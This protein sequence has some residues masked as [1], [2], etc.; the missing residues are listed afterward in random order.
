MQKLTNGTIIDDKYCVLDF[1]GIGGM[2]IVY[3]VE[4]L[5]LKAVR[6]LKMIDTNK[7]S[8]ENWRRFQLEARAASTLEHTNI[9]KV[10]DYGLVNKL[11]P[12]Y[13]ME[14]VDGMTLGERININGPINT[15]QFFSVFIPVAQALAYIHSKGILH[16]D[17]K[18]AN[19]MLKEEING[20]VSQVKVLDFGLVKLFSDA[21]C[22]VLT[23][24]GALTKA[25]EIIGSPTFMSP[26]QTA[27]RKLDQRSDIYS[28]GCAMF[29]ALTGEPP[30]LDYN[31][32]E[33]LIMHQSKPIPRLA[34]KAQEREFDERIELLVRVM[35]AKKPGDRHQ[36]MEEVVQDLI[37]IQSGRKPLFAIEHWQD[38][39]EEENDDIEADDTESDDVGRVTKRTNIGKSLIN[40]TSVITIAI[41]VTAI[42]TLVATSAY[43]WQIHDSGKTPNTKATAPGLD[44]S[45]SIEPSHRY[46]PS[47]QYSREETIAGKR[48]II[49]D[50]PK[51]YS[52]GEI[53]ALDGHN[54]C[55]AQGTVTMP[56]GEPFR[57][58]A[59]KDCMRNPQLLEQFKTNDL[60]ALELNALPGAKDEHIAAIKHLTKLA[61]LTICDCSLSP[62]GIAN[63]GNLTNLKDLTINSANFDDQAFSQLKILD[64]LD[65]FEARE[66]PQLSKTLQAL[67]NSQT[68]HKLVLCN[69]S[70]ND[71][72]LKSI[73]QL[74]QLTYLN[75][76]LNPAITSGG[77]S[78]L[79]TCS[80]LKYLNLI[81][82]PVTAQVIPTLSA[83]KKLTC[84]KLTALDWKEQDDKALK[85]NLPQ[86]CELQLLHIE[87]NKA[88]KDLDNLIN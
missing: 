20:K 66:I 22:G 79:S 71:Q 68:L 6:A 38:T 15:E 77:T 34:E 45:H 62:A 60:R 67:S 65:T 18:P 17:I 8:E 49:F 82:N 23:K 27:G 36:K 56:Q 59:S 58:I 24:A 2:G 42:T 28:L 46:A 87:S 52:I 21:N 80:E 10:Y 76:A 73:G 54:K 16:R 32:V 13:V 31:P 72:S 53:S 86:N 70:V 55:N 84:L 35:L 25:D 88:S 19:I 11:T 40:Y 39:N 43:V 37:A 30:Y 75:L 83:L 7:L 26:E 61:K 85:K 3:K 74:K 41:V 78:A 50:F 44:Q 81:Q 9:I 14:V 63:L 4:Q 47:P 1:L 51:D 33:V 29:D 57:F 12:Y 69:G 5:S 64:Q 48:V